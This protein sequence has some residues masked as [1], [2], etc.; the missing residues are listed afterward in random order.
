MGGRYRRLFGTRKQVR[1]EVSAY[2]GR[3]FMAIVRVGLILGLSISTER[4]LEFAL[5]AALWWEVPGR[6]ILEALRK[7]EGW[8][9]TEGPQTVAM[10]RMEGEESV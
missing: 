2:L 6:A 4:I 7:G 10:L 9:A 3:L 5:T 1:D 8:R